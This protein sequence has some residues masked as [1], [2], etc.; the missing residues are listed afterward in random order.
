VGRINNNAPSGSEEKAMLEK[1][2][3]RNSSLSYLR[4]F[5]TLL[6]VAHHSMLAYTTYAPPVPNDLTAQPRWWQAFPVVD[7][8]RWVGF[9]YLVG[10]ND[11]FFM[12]LMF[13][14]SGLF[15]WP[16]LRRKGVAEF[17]KHRLLRLGLPFA[18]SIVVLAPLAYYATYL[19]S[20]A[21]P[22][23]P[24]FARTWISLRNWPGGPAWFLWLLL[25]FDCVAVALF[26]LVPRAIE[27][28]GR[29]WSKAGQRP[30]LFYFALAAL[31][32]V[33][34]VAMVH[35]YGADGWSSF[36][37]FVFQTSRLLHYLLYFLVGVCVGAVGIGDGLLASRGWLARRWLL[38]GLVMA[39]AYVGE[40][41]V[42]LSG[43]VLAAEI[44]FALSCAASSL[45]LIAVFLRFDF[46]HGAIARRLW[47]SLSENAY[48]IY[49][50]HYIF[51]IWL[52]FLLLRLVLPGAAK[53][54]VVFAGAVALS[55]M[56]VAAL[57]RAPWIARVI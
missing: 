6:V 38:W 28:A 57:R 47:D 12:S 36:G 37:P 31:S 1:L 21:D 11:I 39:I 22:R 56:T 45:F 26:L 46:G 8:A 42:Y 23:L 43:L 17:L 25:A 9:N 29:F 55:W 20:G 34:Y 48:G 4:A 30:V 51:A 2:T 15:V 24:A 7:P 49:L 44:G 14:L 53:G 13:F 40:I 41:V 16:S 5:V 27:L 52:Q 18:V 35:A 32:A 33:V 54:L 3:T 19:L 50:V 10:W